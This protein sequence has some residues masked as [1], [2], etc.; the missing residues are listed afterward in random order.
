LR[1]GS[2]S[3]EYAPRMRITVTQWQR[4]YGRE[5]EADFQRWVIEVAQVFGWRIAH[6][7][8][9]RTAK[10]TWITPMQGDPGWPDLVLARQG[11]LILAELK[12][13]GERPT[14]KQWTWLRVLAS[15][16][17]NEVYVWTPTHREWIEHRLRQKRPS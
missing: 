14:A 1:A 16:P 11:E 7:R 13:A 12:R 2:L 17:W 10:G 5:R 6:F 15:V 8:P 3:G 9:A 4:T